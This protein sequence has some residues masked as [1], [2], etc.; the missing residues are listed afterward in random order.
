MRTNV[1]KLHEMWELRERVGT[2]FM[3]RNSGKTLLRVHE[4]AAGICLGEHDLFIVSLTAYHDLMYLIPMIF[5]V[6][7][8]YGIVPDQPSSHISIER[9]IV[10]YQGRRITIRFYAVRDSRY[11]CRD[12][13]TR[14]LS[15]FG[16]VPMG[17]WD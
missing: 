11:S 17:H 4:L 7:A 8:E 2:A 15:D 5:S 9:L 6:F 1:E 14:G 16:Y 13:F 3:P 10:H 12:E